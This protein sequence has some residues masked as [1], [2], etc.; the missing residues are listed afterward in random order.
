M[1]RITAVQPA[2][3]ALAHDRV[4]L[5]VDNGQHAFLVRD[6]RRNDHLAQLLPVLGTQGGHRYPVVLMGRI[7]A[8]Q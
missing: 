2:Q 6:I 1:V 4:A 3:L 5:A 8:R 7:L